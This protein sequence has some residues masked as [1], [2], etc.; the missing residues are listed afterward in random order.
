MPQ[1]LAEPLQPVHDVGMDENRVALGRAVRDAR[2]RLGMT[3][4]QLSS[5][6]GLSR[7]TIQ[8]LERGGVIRPQTLIKIDGLLGWAPGSG[9]GILDGADAPV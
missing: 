5:A 3:Q 8:S 2:I 1:V 6:A 9:Q 4:A 7:A